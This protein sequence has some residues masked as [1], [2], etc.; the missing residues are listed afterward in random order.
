MTKCLIG[1][2]ECCI[3]NVNQP[4]WPGCCVSMTIPCYWVQEILNSPALGIW[5]VGVC[6]VLVNKMYL[7][8]SSFS[9]T[10]KFKAESFYVSYAR[11]SCALA[12]EHGK[13]QEKVKRFQRMRNRINILLQM[14]WKCKRIFVSTFNKPKPCCK[15]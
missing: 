14:I 10:M 13:A 3:T 9:F 4:L 1:K 11:S 12:Q 6:F 15:E 2:G 5:L 8:R 7:F